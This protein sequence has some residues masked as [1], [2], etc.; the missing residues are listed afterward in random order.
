MHLHEELHCRV[1]GGQTDGGLDFT[2]KYIELAD[3]SKRAIQVTRSPHQVVIS[4]LLSYLS[5]YLCVCDSFPAWSPICA[6]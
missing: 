2:D 1:A 4:V 3:G 5:Y 6:P